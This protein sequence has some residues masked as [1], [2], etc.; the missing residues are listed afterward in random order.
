MAPDRS[1]E[2]VGDP[3]KRAVEEL[4]AAPGIGP[5]LGRDLVALG[6]HG[7]EELGASDPEELYE[8][9]C[10]RCG[11]RV[12]RCV[13]YAFRCAVYFASREEHDPELLKWW[14]WKDRSPISR[15]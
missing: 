10:H 8:R 3:L 5:S 13:L 1:G 9:H 15:A 2:P 4:Q 14:S 12:D 7:L 11:C 6:I